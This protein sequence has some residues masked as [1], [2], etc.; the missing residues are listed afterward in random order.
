M[1][2]IELYD[3]EADAINARDDYNY[4]LNRRAVLA[5]VPAD[6]V[7][8]YGGGPKERIFAENIDPFV[9]ML[10]VEDTL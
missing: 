3:N 9:W 8:D 4:N 10:I 7:L 2:T 1:S 5:K 6:D